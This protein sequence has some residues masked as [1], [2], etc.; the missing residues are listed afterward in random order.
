[1]LACD[2]GDADAVELLHGLG[3]K[4]SAKDQVCSLCS[5]ARNRLPGP[6]G[7]RAVAAL[8]QIWQTGLMFAS[9]RGHTAV[10]AL[11]HRLGADVAAADQ[12]WLR[13]RRPVAVG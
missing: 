5:A 2:N 9:E 10:V 6:H 12:A 3:A 7:T 1:M 13:A 8:E 4:L 11:L